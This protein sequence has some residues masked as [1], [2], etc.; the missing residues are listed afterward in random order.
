V[1]LSG[2]M[3]TAGDLPAAQVQL[4]LIAQGVV[5]ASTATNDDGRFQFFVKVVIPEGKTIDVAVATTDGAVTSNSVILKKT[6]P[7]PR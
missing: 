2:K 5:I 6:R 4:N 7:M 1:R 3:L